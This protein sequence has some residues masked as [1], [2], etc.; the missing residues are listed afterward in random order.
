MKEIKAGRERWPKGIGAEATSKEID[1]YITFKIT[2]YIHYNFQ[3]DELWELYQEDFKGFSI[4]TF[5]DCN[6]P[7]IRKL[8][9]LLRSNGV[10]VRKDRRKTVA[11]SLYNTL[12]EEEPAEWTTQEIEEYIRTT[13][14]F[15]S[16]QINYMLGQNDAASSAHARTAVPPDPPDLPDPLDPSDFPD[17]YQRSVS[18]E[19]GQP[20]REQSFGKELAN[21]AKMYTDESRYSGE[22]DNF[23]YKLV[24]FHDLCSRVDIPDNIK[25]KAYPTMLRSL[26]LDHYYTSIKGA[27]QT[28]NLSFEQICDSTR[29]YFEGPEYKRG[30]LGRWN[31]TTLRGVM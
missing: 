5:K 20:A 14:R 27:I 15:N 2:E 26:A 9:A 11:E 12:Q 13:G 1:D 10:W 19:P 29:N 22:N 24:I 30:V 8:R 4:A 25:A 21:L 7:G 28:Y 18:K 17:P 23:D 16:A 6:Q 3:D 31:L